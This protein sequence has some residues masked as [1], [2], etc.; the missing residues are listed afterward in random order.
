[1]IIN[2]DKMHFKGIPLRCLPDCTTARLHNCMTARL[3]NF[4]SQKFTYF[5][6]YEKNNP[7]SVPSVHHCPD[8]N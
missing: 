5:G 7:V 6:V 4:F 8:G 1:M 2:I 3:P